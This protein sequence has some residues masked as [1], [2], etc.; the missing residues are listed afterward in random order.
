MRMTMAA[1]LLLIILPAPGV[2]QE[3]PLPQTA[4]PRPIACRALE[5]HTDKELN[6]A[7]IIFHQRDEAERDRLAT[8]LHAHSG[9]VVEIRA[10]DSGWRRARLLRL[11]SC[12]GRGLLLV[13][14]PATISERAEFLLRPLAPE[15]H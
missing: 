13:S 4:E 2:A 10:G 14:A 8:L 6:V 15:P 12:F 1:A 5:S 9:E 11:K 3:A 7:V